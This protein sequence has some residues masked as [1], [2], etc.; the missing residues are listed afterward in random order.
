MILIDWIDLLSW[1]DLVVADWSKIKLL[2]LTHMWGSWLSISGGSGNLLVTY[3]SS[4]KPTQAH[5][6]G[7]GHRI[8]KSIEKGE[9][10]FK[11]LLV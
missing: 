2:G 9:G 8:F 3:L 4:N 5:L 10:L 11:S 7:G 1:R 6:H